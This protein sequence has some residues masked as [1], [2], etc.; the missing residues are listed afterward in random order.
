MPASSIVEKRA[1]KTSRLKTAL[2]FKLL[3]VFLLSTAAMGQSIDGTF[4]VFGGILLLVAGGFIVSERPGC[5]FATALLVVCVLVTP[6]ST[7][8]M[9]M[10]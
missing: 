10:K 7:C 1:D 9:P 2:P 4:L 5:L 8:S 6:L 3:A